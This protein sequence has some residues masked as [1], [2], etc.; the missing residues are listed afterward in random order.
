MDSDGF[1]GFDVCVDVWKCREGEIEVRVESM[2]HD[3]C[4]RLSRFLFR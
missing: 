2:N 1:D 3:P 4:P